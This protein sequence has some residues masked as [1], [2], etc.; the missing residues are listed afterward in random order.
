[1]A[2]QYAILR[3]DKLK[4]K[5]NIAAQ[6]SHVERT[7]PTPNA[8]PSRTHLN[9]WLVGGPGMYQSSKDVWETIPKMRSDAVLALD[10]LMTASPEAFRRPDFD[11]DQW[12]EDSVR[13][14]KKHFKGAEIVGLQLQL[15]ESTPHLQGIIIPTDKKP[16]GTLQLNAK[17]WLGGKAKL[18]AMQSSYARSVEHHGLTRGIEGSEAKHEKISAFYGA[19]NSESTAK[20]K[21][22]RVA[23]PPMLLTQKARQAWADEQA[24]AIRKQ[25]AGPVSQ[26]MHQSN[27]GIMSERQVEH[28]KRENSRINADLT[29]SRRRE[30]EAAA[31]L[32][33]LPLEEVAQVLGCYPTKHDKSLWETPAGKTTIKGA[34]FFNHEI[35]KGGGGAF[36]LVMH[37][38][39]CTYIEALAFL[40]DEFD[41]AAAIRAAA[42]AARRQ[43]AEAVKKATQEPFRPPQHVEAH[44]PR[45]RHY[46]TEIRSLASSLVDKLRDSGWL[47]ADDR[48]NAFF[49]KMDGNRITSSELRGTGQSKFK[50]SRGRSS[51]GVFQVL[52]Q[53]AKKLAICESAIDAISYVQTHIGCSA[54]ATGG[55]GKHASASAYLDKHRGDYDQVVCAS[56][57]GD[58]GREMAKVL[59]LPHDGPPKGFDD[60]NEYAQAV[61]VNPSIS[62]NWQAEVTAQADQRSEGPQKRSERVLDDDLAPS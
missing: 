19:I 3:I 13:W 45:V 42:D 40:R 52:I 39:D 29:E 61:A 55:T 43:A 2:S 34:K 20:F 47:G 18:S 50:G 30:K 53:G 56:D 21:K 6:A 15:D 24:A 37:M 59:G 11:L 9:R 5:G 27:A 10:V 28:L 4:H 12:T 22:I 17:K 7:R 51:E 8:D 1:M 35:E 54:I 23:Q 16:D 26:L 14:L 57:N 25:I 41:P 44:W 48:K 31:E 60:W 33:S 49:L 62:A 38:R 58:G 36:D 46:L 32:R